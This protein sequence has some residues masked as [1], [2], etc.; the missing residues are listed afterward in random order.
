MAKWKITKLNSELEKL[1]FFEE[2]FR[3]SL[4]EQF[5]I[6]TA[7]QYEIRPNLTC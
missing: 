4:S 5:Y 3:F 7:Y 6:T 1:R 2:V